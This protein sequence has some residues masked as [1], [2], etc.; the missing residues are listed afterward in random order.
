MS[1]I[2]DIYRDDSAE[3][4]KKIPDNSVDLIVTTP[5]YADQRKKLTEGSIPTP[6]RRV[7]FADLGRV[8][9]GAEA[10]GDFYP[11]Y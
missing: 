3:R 8:A 4:L 7:V 9:A 6:V 2:I 5:P 11:E 10:Y 1:V